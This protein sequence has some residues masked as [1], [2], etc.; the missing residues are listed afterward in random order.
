MARLISK[1]GVD[2]REEAADYWRA[3]N[4]LPARLTR[5]FRTLTAAG[6]VRWILAASGVAGVVIGAT[7]VI[8][9]LRSDDDQTGA[10]PATTPTATATLERLLHGRFEILPRGSIPLT[11]GLTVPAGQT[12]QRVDIR[13]APNFASIGPHELAF[14]PDVPAGWTVTEVHAE[15]V[16]WTDGTRTDSL[17]GVEFATPGETV[18][19]ALSAMEDDCVVQVVDDRDY[20]LTTI[21]G[22][23]ALAHRKPPLMLNWFDGNVLV[24]LEAGTESA[25]AAVASQLLAR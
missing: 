7:V 19:F 14:E 17:F 9:A 12:Q 11:C 21:G 18:R 1:L 8:L 23:P 22:R 6:T 16:V 15:T 4:G 24:T 25:L 2:T 5:L 13:E 3:Y 20:E 10:A